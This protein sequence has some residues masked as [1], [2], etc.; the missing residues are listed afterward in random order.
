MRYY[1]T[2]RLV[3]SLT[4][5]AAVTDAGGRYAIAFSSAPWGPSGGPFY[6]AQAELLSDVHE[7][8]LRDVPVK[9]S[10]LVENFRLRQVVRVAPG[11]SVV[12]T[13]DPEN[14]KS[15]FS[16][17]PPVA[18]AHVPV[19]TEGML[20]ISAAVDGQPQVKLGIVACCSNGSE[21]FGNP[22]TIPVTPALREVLVEVGL[23]F[24]GP[25]SP[26]YGSLRIRL[27]TSF[28]PS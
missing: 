7:W 16:W 23:E 14:G 17:L 21:L 1:T 3:N 19:S 9:G 20:R 22:V 28:D 10:E 4:T 13:A 24:Q 2:P 25:F 12:L 6:A 26:S 5:S 15:L 18:R 27:M 11:D 8:I